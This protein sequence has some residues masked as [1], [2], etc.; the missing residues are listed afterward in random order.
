M[1]NYAYAYLVFAVLFFFA[2]VASTFAGKTF[3]RYGG[4]AHRDKEPIQ[5]WVTV[6]LYYLGGVY[7]MVKYFLP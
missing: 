2:G 5:F 4:W 7:F 1:S 3:A 6:A